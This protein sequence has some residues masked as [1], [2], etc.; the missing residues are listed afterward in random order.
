MGREHGDS[1]SLIMDTQFMEQGEHRRGI[2]RRC[3][4][5]QVEGQRH[6]FMRMPHCRNQ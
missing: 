4:I 3:A 5:L 1:W 6:N 2:R